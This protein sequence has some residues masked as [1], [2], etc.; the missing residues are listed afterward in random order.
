MKK[1]GNCLRGAVLASLLLTFA[2][3]AYADKQYAYTLDYSSIPSEIYKRQITLIV[4]VGTASSCA[5][6]ADGRAVASSYDAGSGN[7]VFSLTSTAANLI[8][9]AVNWT[10]GGTGAVTKATFFG[11]KKWA[12]SFTFD[13]NYAAVSSI[14]Y[15]YFNARN[16]RG[17]IG[18]VTNWIG[19]GGYLSR[20]QLDAL[21][22]AGWG[23]LN[24][25]TSH[26]QGTISC[27]N[28]ATYIGAAKTTLETWYPNN[29]KSIYFIYPYLEM[30]YKTC[31]STSGYARGAEG[32]D[33]TNYA[34]NFAAIDLFGLYRHGLYA[35]VSASQAN[36]WAD[37]AASNSRPVWNIVFTHNVVAGSGTPGTYDTNQST[38]ESH[39]NYVYTTYGEGGSTRN[40]WFAPSDEVLMYL[41]TRQ[42]LVINTAA[43]PT[44]TRTITPSFTRTVTLTSTRTVTPAPTFTQTA[45]VP[46]VF[47]NGADVG[48]LSQMEASGKIFYD[49]AG[50]QKD[51]LQIL[52]EH[53]VNSI[54]LRVWVNPTGGWCG[55]T[56]VINM[57]VRAK[58]M[59]FR[60][61]IDFHYSDSWADPGQQTKP[62]AWVSYNFT[63]LRQ[64]VYD[65]TVDV[66]SGLNAAGVTP[67]WVQVGNETNN[68]MLWEDGR[69][70]VNMANFA[71]LVTS[72]YDGVKAVFPSAKVIVH[73]SNGYDNALFRWIFDGLKNNGGKWDVIGM[74][75]YPEPTDW[76]TRNT[77]CLS[78]MNDMITRY[79]GKEVMISE[80]G[81]A[82][83]QAQA[84]HDFIADIINKTKSLPDQKGLGVFYWEP[85][86]YN[87]AGYTKGAW[88]TNGRP[89][90][91]M[92]AFLENCPVQMPSA[93][94]SAQVSPTRT[95]TF[96]GTRTVTG[97]FT[98]TAT[99]T[100]SRT[101]TIT[102]SPTATHTSTAT[103]YFSQSF[104]ATA[105]RTVTNTYTRT[106]VPPTITYT[107]TATATPSMTL[108]QNAPSA[109]LTR[110]QTVI[111]TPSCPLIWND[112]FEGPMI[113][114][115]KWSFETGAGGWGNN[116]L[117]YYTSR[118]QNARIESGNLVIEARQ[119]SYGGSNY[120]SARIKTQAK[121]SHRYG[122]VEARIK[123]PYGQGIWPAFWTLGE[124]ISSVGWPAC[125]EIDIMEMI[126]GGEN[127][128]DTTYGTAHWDNAGSHAQYGGSR[129]LPDPQWFY[130]DYHIF[131]I[132]WDSQYIRWFLDG[133]QF[134]VIDITPAELSEF[135][136][137]QFIILNLAVGGNWPG[138]PDG[139]TVFP[140]KMYV[141]WVR[142]YDC[143][144]G[145][146]TM[147]AVP[148]S[149]YT[150]TITQTAIVPSATFTAT[151][152]LPT[153]TRTSTVTAVPPTAT[154]T[155]TQTQVAATM[156]YTRTNTV[157]VPTATHTRTATGTPI[158]S[159]TGTQIAPSP[160]A[161]VPSPTSTGVPATPTYT[162][163]GTALPSATY[164]MTATFTASVLPSATRTATNTFTALP[165]GSA[166]NTRTATQ[167]STPSFTPTATASRTITGTFT[168]TYTRT[169]TMTATLLPTGTATATPTIEVKDRLEIVDVVVFPN[170]IK[171][172]ADLKIK[173]DV[174]RHVSKIHV[175]IYT[176]AYRRVIDETFEGSFLRDTVITV[177]Q[178]KLS[179][180]SAGIYYMSIRAEEG[181]DM[182]GFKTLEVVLIK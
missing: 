83:D 94:A 129:E 93:T 64:A 33:G 91:A 74:S 134:H 119:E 70:S 126:G 37:A 136:E 52:K 63:Q 122:R 9:N 54:R 104:T 166:T 160:T 151:T 88:G 36:A 124:S 117:E 34:D 24:H 35:N 80:V 82:W 45:V 72:G 174:T 42:Y 85:E 16:L 32:V 96:T 56:D 158:A 62:A 144:A 26:P 141:D 10:S 182:S 157:T 3:S 59:G 116:E 61:M 149:T 40:M 77:Q 110:T 50:V 100:Q 86:C 133:V 20:A 60:I 169:L 147:T 44:A 162:S 179:R 41:Y 18:V 173:F 8:I 11:N 176:T 30:G 90:L 47:A 2:V 135:R 58:N 170:P 165:T 89:T 12:Y 108:T 154:Y 76:Q 95:P 81:M 114:T 177:P 27:A 68:G 73:I 25:S 164:T 29:Y 159:P 97:T 112:E 181:S 120:T 155:G 105:T 137:N 175:R 132:E 84:S 153:S 87:W 150:R 180:L 55:K 92:D 139:T 115:G 140:Q 143:P 78:N 103:P 28:L 142:W 48:W 17:G 57:A 21:F 4:N 67:D 39:I 161:Q 146:A 19:G 1:A 148:S 107:R 172:P 22:N 111:Y 99:G 53:C 109:T 101:I 178:R 145:T 23:I 138:S 123:L 51:C 171:Q 15:P 46:F 102:A 167:T 106:P 6:T 7:C 128:D 113:D 118:T 75:L 121:F 5:V 13:D 14:V 156:T 79:P 69:A 168:P 127:R 49:D 66:L 98:R 31:L 43:L 125:G 130:E 163:T 71:Q 152:V 38:L 65:H 131:G